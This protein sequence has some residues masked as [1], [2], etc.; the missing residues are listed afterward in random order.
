ME[1]EADMSSRP[2]NLLI[3]QKAAPTDSK[4]TSFAFSQAAQSKELCYAPI[5]SCLAAEKV[6]MSM[7][8]Q[9]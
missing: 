3:L 9:L 2:R 1:L 4:C 8:F 6:K 7:V 5:L